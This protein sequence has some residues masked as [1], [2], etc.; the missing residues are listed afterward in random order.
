MC[1]KHQKRYI[2]YCTDCRVT[3]CHGCWSKKHSKHATNDLLEE[4]QSRKQKLKENITAREENLK[5]YREEVDKGFQM[6]ESESSS[7]IDEMRESREFWIKE[8]NFFFDKLEGA[9]VSKL[10]EEK[11][12]KDIFESAVDK[13]L[14]RINA[15]KT[16]CDFL[17][18]D[19]MEAVSK[20]EDEIN[21]VALESLR[22]KHD[23]SYFENKRFIPVSG[24]EL[25][26]AK[27]KVVSEMG[28]LGKYKQE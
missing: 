21:K 22:V 11:E 13:L 4:V 20:H 7:S 3:L 9:M 1:P 28:S 8:M 17:A 25:K 18:P 5:N 16:M 10:A 27:R 12:R 26:T 24:G 15:T 2:L 19:D 14:Q 6:F 23:V